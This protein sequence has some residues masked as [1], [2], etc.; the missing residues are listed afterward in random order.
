MEELRLACL[1]VFDV[2]QSTNLWCEGCSAFKD[3]VIFN[4]F[5]EVGGGEAIPMGLCR[6][7][8]LKGD[9]FNKGV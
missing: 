2:A 7:C 1:R 5:L 4:V 6:D 3:Y 8:Y 9:V